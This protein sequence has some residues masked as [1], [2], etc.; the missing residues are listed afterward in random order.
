MKATRFTG[1]ARWARLGVGL[2]LL[3]AGVVAPSAQ[4]RPV[5]FAKDIAPL[6]FE[7][8]AGCHQ[9]G[10]LGP[11]SILTYDSARQHATQI[12]L[13]T[14]SRRMPPWNARSDYGGFV[15]QQPLSEAEIDLIQRW[16]AQGAVEGNPRD[17]P[18][19]PELTDGWQLGKPDLIVTLPEPFVLAAEGSS[20]FRNFVIPVPV[21]SVRYVK[22]L[23]F[24]SGNARVV[25]HSNVRID[26]TAASRRLDEED[27]A[28]GYE[29][30]IPRSAVYPDGHFLAWTPGQVAPLLPKGLAWRL[31]PGTD[32]AVEVHMYPDGKA[33]AVQPSI[34]LFFGP[35]PPTRT[36]AML[37]LGRQNID[38]PAGE[39][40]YVV[41][42]SF[43]LPVEVDVQ[44]VQPH[45]HYR[46][47]DVRATATLPDG[48]TRTL[49][50]IPDWDYGFQHLYRYVA[51]FK[52]PA[53]TALAMRYEYDNSGD[54]PRNPDRPPQRVRWGPRSSDEM[55]H[56]GIQVFTATERDYATLEARMRPK[57]NAEDIVGY[58]RV[59]ELEPSSVALH[60]DVAGLYLEMG[61]PGEAISHFTA[62]ADLAPESPAAQFN[63]GLAL[64]IGGR[65][66]EAIERYRRALALRPD[67]ALA[68]NNLGSVLLQRGRL[69]E[70]LHHVRE[71]VRIDPSNP[72]AQNNLG[73][74]SRERGDVPDALDHFR[75][76]V[77]LRP[78]WA[79]AHSDLAWTL[80]TSRDEKSGDPTEAVRLAERAA[81]LTEHRDPAVLDVLAAAYAA[82]GA[83]DRAIAASEAAL[84]LGPPAI[85]AA[86]IRAR[87]EL[88]KQHRPYRRP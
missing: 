32:L 41:A 61:R 67:Y 20:V 65:I 80:A 70:A 49:I 59:I 38:I 81:G 28:P 5:T 14:R 13:V 68:H 72:E 54:N 73:R 71:A 84:R 37:R 16:I 42:D 52:L 22:G 43:V 62:S 7:R 69:D 66:D 2:S 10:G 12:G 24:H 75:Q 8:C 25:H 83:F 77:S 11:F 33:E 27:P 30:L 31:D 44:A 64:T 48:T 45:A 79:A 63:L 23:E 35:D 3:G 6:V 47:K 76:A 15:G 53:G 58:E 55:G 29:G 36:P 1:N 82:A 78:N 51:P 19:S 46:A 40:H 4:G 39:K 57:V 26:P 85:G 9:P 50:H 56:L 87:L 74:I 34:G 17:L 88:Y 18:P 86:A 21:D 60:D